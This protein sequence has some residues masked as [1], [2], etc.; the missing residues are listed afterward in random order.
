MCVCR[1]QVLLLLGRMSATTGQIRQ[2]G[3][4]AR[5]G[6]FCSDQRLLRHPPSGG[7]SA[8]VCMCVS[9]F[10][11]SVDDLFCLWENFSNSCVRCS[12]E[13]VYVFCVDTSPRAV[14]S[15]A[16]AASL[17]AI[18]HTIHELHKWATGRTTPKQDMCPELNDVWVCLVIVLT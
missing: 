10:M 13:P 1:G 14:A 4:T 8:Y 3:A 2:A 17:A 6:G 9:W 16:M 7:S 12:Q 18:Q 15:G 11:C 5:L